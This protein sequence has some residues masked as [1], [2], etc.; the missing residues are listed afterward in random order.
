VVLPTALALMVCNMDR[1]C[2]AVAIVPMAAEF[3]WAPSTQGIVQS[4]FLWGYMLTQFVG[5][6]L[7]DKHGGE[8]SSTCC[9]L[10]RCHCHV[11]SRAAKLSTLR[12][13]GKVVMAFG[14]VWFSLASLLLP[15]VVMPAVSVGPST[16]CT[17][18]KHFP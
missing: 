12:A 6:S 9:R 8:H 4:A 18:L 17:W 10:C 1:I 15:L 3:G 2:M 11:V 7:A 14:I 13:A 16:Q 5:G